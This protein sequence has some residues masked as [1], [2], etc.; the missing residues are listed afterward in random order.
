MHKSVPAPLASTAAYDRILQGS[1]FGDRL[2]P[3][4]IARNREAAMT[5]EPICTR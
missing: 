4:G 5:W 2:V 3:R 1:P